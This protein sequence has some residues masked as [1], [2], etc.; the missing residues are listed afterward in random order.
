MKLSK[1]SYKNNSKAQAV[2]GSQPAI[3]E[4]RLPPKMEAV[5]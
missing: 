1:V 2:A 4:M 3:A 5:I